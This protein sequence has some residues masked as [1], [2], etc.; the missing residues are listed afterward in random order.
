[1]SLLLFNVFFLRLAKQA[2][3]KVT[4]KALKQKDKRRRREEIKEILCVDDT[5][6][7]ELGRNDVLN[8]LDEFGRA[9]DI[10]SLRINVDKV[11]VLVV[12]KR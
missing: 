1:M 5:V 10:M 12:R 4:W 8:I 9:C 11:K 6:M 2:I 7:M 3:E